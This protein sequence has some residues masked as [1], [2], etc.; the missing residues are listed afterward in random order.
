MSSETAARIVQRSI[1]GKGIAHD[2]AARHVAGEAAYIDDMPE[3]PGTLHGALVLSPVAHGRLKGVDA[4]E[5][6]AMEGVAGF[7][8]AGDVPGHNEVGP[9]HT[10]EP[11]FAE[12]IL[13]HE[14]QVIGIVAARDFETAYRA[15]KRVR[16]DIEKLDPVLDIEEAHRRKNYVVPLQEVVDGDAATAIDAAPHVF[17]GTLR[18]GGQDHFYLETHIAYAIPGENGE[19][20]VHSSTQ[21]PTEVQHH[22]AGILGIHANAVECQVRRMGGGFGGKESQP[23]I[24]AGA[25]AL[26]AVKT[27]RPCKLRLKRRDDMAA[28]GKRHDFVV[29]WRVGTDATGRIHGL[30]AEYLARAGNVADLTGPVITRALTHTDNAYHIAHA[31]FAGHAC[32]TNTV[33]NT[34]FRGFGGPQGI[35]TIEAVIDTIARKLKLDPN[36]VRGVN[37]Y[38][39]DTGDMTPYGQKVEDNRLVE[40]TEAVLASS[41]WQRRRAEIDRHNSAD[42]VIRRGLAMMP[43][44]FGISFNLTS[45]NQAGALVHVYLD[46][47]IFL[48]HGGTEMGQGL[49]VK[50]AQVVAEVFQVDLDM[51]RISSTA[52]G[53]VPNTSATAA[54]TGSDLNGMAAYKA[55]TAIKARMTRVAAEHFGVGEELILFREGRVHAGNESISFGELA[56][57]AW[58][59]RVQLSEAGHYATPKIHWDGKAMKGRPFFYFS[60]GAAVAEV[61]VDT[62]TGETRCLRA[63][64]L[65]DVGSPLNPAIDLGQIEGAFVQG[66]GWVTCEELWWDGAGKL[67]TVGPSTY[68]IP[69]SRDVPPAFNV[70]ILD[71]LPNREETVYRSKAIGEPP[72]ML[73]ISVW[74]AIRDAIASIDGDVPD[75]DAPATPEAVLRA[76]GIAK[77]RK[78]GALL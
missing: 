49:F 69:G 70:R 9:I 53:K 43:V 21:H 78:Q 30:E 56:K 35:I 33:S 17:S 75:L 3:L 58:A 8:S 44:K 22:V 20:L 36:R 72:L 60:Y 55:A 32:K 1:V 7:W 76:V 12:T 29:H 10:G 63:D 6:L 51:V 28:T 15:A 66:M 39:S 74:L 59:K 24:I 16:L 26:V 23:T 73:G 54:S 50:V 4:S 40:V 67:R 38:G 2:S 19:M 45:L 37:Y 48:N 68:K 62:L 27:G 71:N 11:L 13:E 5:A 25:A 77:S 47:S 14:G 57:L 18:M 42:P 41:E 65:Q 46:G 31:R 34:A 61:A 52:T 64:I